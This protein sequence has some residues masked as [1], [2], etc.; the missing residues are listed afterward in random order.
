LGDVVECGD[1]LVLLRAASAGASSVGSTQDGPLSPRIGRAG[2][3]HI[4]DGGRWFE[5]EGGMRI[6]LGR[7]GPL[8]RALIAL[9]RLRLATPGSGLSTE[10]LIEA[11]WPGEKIVHDAALA[12]A[13]TTI[14]RLRSLGLQHVLMTSDEGYL[15][16]PKVALR[17]DGR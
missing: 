3:L 10:K 4:G 5:L 14:Q 6:N 7:R 2:Q 11:G 15:L 8:R 9:A 12:R 1:I 13:Y 17:W 16:D